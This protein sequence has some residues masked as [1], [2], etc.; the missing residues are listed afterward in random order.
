VWQAASE[1][2]ER[3]RAGAGPT[4]IEALT[5]APREA[6][7]PQL[8]EDRDPIHRFRGFLA[9]RGLWS[10]AWEQ[11]ISERH[12]REVGAALAAAAGKQPPAVETL[13]DDVYEQLPWH[14]REQRAHLM[15][16]T[17]AKTLHHDG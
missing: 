4:L 5:S 1:A 6:N 16:Q 17:R 8:R 13:F 2:I 11:A 9:H 7:Q 14:L 15:Q 12:D 3:A 10:D